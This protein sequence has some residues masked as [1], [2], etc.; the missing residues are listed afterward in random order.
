[1]N[2]AA[3][4]A[5]AASLVRFNVELAAALLNVSRTTFNHRASNPEMHCVLA[6]PVYSWPVRASVIS[7]ASNGAEG[8]FLFEYNHPFDNSSP[9]RQT[10]D[11]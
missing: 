8:A 1:M 2:N 9:V 4:H 7:T 11:V 6:R 3:R 5:C 10:S